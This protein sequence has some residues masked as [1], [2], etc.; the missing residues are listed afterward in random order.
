MAPSFAAYLARIECLTPLTPLDAPTPASRSLPDPSSA[1]TSTSPAKRPRQDSPDGTTESSSPPSDLASYFTS[2]SSGSS[3]AQPS[4][5]RP[6]ACI[7]RSI[8]HHLSPSTSSDHHPDEPTPDTSPD[9]SPPPSRALSRRSSA[10]GKSVRFARCT[11]ASVF[12]ALSGDEYDRSPIIPTCQSESLALPKRKRDEAEGWIK[13]VERERAAA[14][15]RKAA[16][17]APLSPSTACDP[18]KSPLLGV[19]SPVE[20]VHGLIE[21]GYHRGDEHDETGADIGHS[22]ADDDEDLDDDLGDTDYQDDGASD[23]PMDED[24]PEEDNEHDE[25]PELSMDDS[26][27]SDSDEP[28]SVGSAD[29][30]LAQ[31]SSIH[32]TFVHST[33]TLVAAAV[34][35]SEQQ[36]ASPSLGFGSFGRCVSIA[37]EEEDEDA[38]AQELERERAAALAAVAAAAASKQKCR[39]RYGICALGKYTRA[40]VFQSYDS[41]GGF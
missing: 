17:E 8:L 32:V 3:L 34:S 26:G 28:L 33:V 35:S 38:R 12:P 21:G 30:V 6:N 9:A 40:E 10:S 23:D 14:A 27:A 31:S 13:C 39:D 41:L 24:D 36:Q 15:K 19:P 7:L 37:P 2:S 16:G 1:L 5:T 4:P 29:V 25:A 18:W 11:N 22:R 20:G